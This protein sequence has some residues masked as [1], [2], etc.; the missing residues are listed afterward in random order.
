MSLKITDSIPFLY[1][2]TLFLKV[3]NKE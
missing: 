2:Y 1:Y 3:C